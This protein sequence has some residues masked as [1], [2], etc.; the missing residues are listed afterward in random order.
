MSDAPKPESPVRAQ[1]P[2]QTPT[3]ITKRFPGAESESVLDLQSRDR[4]DVVYRPVSIFAVAALIIAASYS[5]YIV[6]GAIVSV[7]QRMPWDVGGWSAIF[8]VL[9]LVLAG[10][11]WFEIQSSEGTRTGKRMAGWAAMLSIMV[12]LGYWAYYG[13]TYFVV[14]NKAQAYCEEFFDKIQQG[15]LESA[16]IM[17]IQPKSRPKENSGLRDEIEFRHNPEPVQSGR[18]GGL[19]NKFKEHLITYV[20]TQGGKDVKFESLGVTSLE[21]KGPSTG[22]IIRFRYRIT[23]PELGFEGLVT[24]NSTEPQGKETKG[25]QWTINMGETSNVPE[26]NLIPI[27]EGVNL[28]RLQR[29]GSTFLADWQNRL[30]S[31]GK[32]ENVEA[33]LSTIDPAAREE[34]ANKYRN[35]QPRAAAAMVG[36]CASDGWSGLT[37]SCAATFATET[38]LPNYDAFTR[39]EMVH[40]ASDFWVPNERFRAM[41]LPAAKAL[42]HTTPDLPMGVLH[43]EPNK[44]GYWSREGD[45]LQFR[46]HVQIRVRSLP[47]AIEGDI[48]TECPASFL[49]TRPKGDGWRVVGINLTNLRAL[50][51]PPA[52][53]GGG[54]PGQMG[55]PGMDN[56]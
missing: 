13:A 52:G 45:K 4:G 25:R 9:A 16:F 1:P 23:G 56:Q 26:T 51:Q 19:F 10:I 28:L 42:F 11:A 32:L 39:G 53:Q 15:K 44:L 40:M 33:Y 3:G 7:I 47:Q 2:S 27:G 21:Y 46:H 31:M 20:I 36:A 48:I 54:D 35:S 12:S 30:R 37:A 34:I 22:Y 17:A 29:S 55:I 5:A 43:I 8:P 18:G 49:Q 14:R 41:A 6:I 24:L 38:Y 50:P